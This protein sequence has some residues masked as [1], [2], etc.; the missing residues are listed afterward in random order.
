[1]DD[2]IFIGD[3]GI[4]EKITGRVEEKYMITKEIDVDEVTFL[5]M[6]IERDAVEMSLQPRRRKQTG[7]W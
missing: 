1:M 4:M 3:K 5:G 7:Y 2:L 6:K